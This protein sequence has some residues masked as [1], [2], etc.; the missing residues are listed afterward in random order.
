MLIKP[1][2]KSSG[3]LAKRVRG[4]RAA[5]FCCAQ[6]RA[7][8]W[9]SSGAERGVNRA[10]LSLAHDGDYATAF[11]ALQYFYLRRGPLGA[12][13]AS[14]SNAF[15]RRCCGHLMKEGPLLRPAPRLWRPRPRL[16]PRPQLPCPPEPARAK[17]CASAESPAPAA[18][19]RQRAAHLPNVCEPRNLSRLGASG[20][21]ACLHQKARRSATAGGHALG[22]NIDPFQ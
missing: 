1:G 5:D 8:R 13:H 4:L 12:R 21:C 6:T 9:S 7:P 10:L 16:A 3:Q 22:W 14:M 19:H 11:V 2:S 20:D 18:G 17:C 15:T